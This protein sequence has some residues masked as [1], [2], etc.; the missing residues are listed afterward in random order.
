ME[1]IEMYIQQTE[2]DELVVIHE[3]HDNTGNIICLQ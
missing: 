1:F 2:Q 3:Q